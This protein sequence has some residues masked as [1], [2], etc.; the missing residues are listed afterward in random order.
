MLLPTV[1]VSEKRPYKTKAFTVAEILILSLFLFIRTYGA[2]NDSLVLC[3][4][5]Q[6]RGQMMYSI[7]RMYL[8]QLSHCLCKMLKRAMAVSGREYF[9]ISR[10]FIFKHLSYYPQYFQQKKIVKK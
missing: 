2:K 6:L 7:C 3:H 8:H 4:I 10:S 5:R 1:D 9:T